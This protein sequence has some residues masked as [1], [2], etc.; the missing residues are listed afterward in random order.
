MDGNQMVLVNED[1]LNDPDIKICA[2]P[3][4]AQLTR[5]YFKGPEQSVT[6]KYVFD[7]SS[8]LSKVITGKADAMMSPFPDKKFFPDSIDTNGDRKPETNPKPLC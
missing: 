5:A 1:L 4:S 6:T 3:L 8:C 2:G 7:I